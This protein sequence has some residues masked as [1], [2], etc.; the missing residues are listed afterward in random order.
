[1][2]DAVI[3]AAGMATALGDGVRENVAAL[4]AG[5]RAFSESRHFDGK[6][7]KLGLRHELDGGD[8]SRAGRLLDLLAASFPEAAKLPQEAPLYLATTVGAI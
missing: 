6:G 4:L 1:M 2:R 5:K 3:A 7:V 8:G